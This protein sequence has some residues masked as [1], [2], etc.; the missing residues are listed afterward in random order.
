ML[1]EMYMLSEISALKFCVIMWYVS[2]AGV[3]GGVPRYA[4]PPGKLVHGYQR[5]L[6]KLFGFQQFDARF[7]NISK[8][9]GGG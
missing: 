8:G 3:G 2:K 6:Y 9:A 7:M 4:L 5:K 1:S